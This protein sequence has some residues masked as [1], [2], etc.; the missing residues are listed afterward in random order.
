MPQCGIFPPRGAMA[1]SC[2]AWK[3]NSKRPARRIP[4]SAL[5]LDRWDSKGG[6]ENAA[7][8]HF[9]APGRTGKRLRRAERKQAAA[10]AENPTL[11]AA[12]E[13]A[14][15]RLLRLFSFHSQKPERAHAAAPPFRKRFRLA[16]LLACKRAHNG[17]PSLPTFCGARE[18]PCVAW[19][20]CFAFG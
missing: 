15:Y 4:P 3:A 8:R 17:S 11:S 9:P 20:L 5:L 12:S 1:R 18:G 13:Q 2:A 16:R 6:T 14:L 7:V 19:A 10:R